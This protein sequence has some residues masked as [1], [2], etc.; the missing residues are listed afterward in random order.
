MDAVH[1]YGVLVTLVIL[2]CIPLIKMTNDATEGH[3]Q[4]LK[5]RQQDVA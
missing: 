2:I 1:I 3:K 4:S 5:Q